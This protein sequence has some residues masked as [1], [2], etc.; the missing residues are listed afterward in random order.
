MLVVASNGAK[1]LQT[2]FVSHL[3]VRNDKF[4]QVISECIHLSSMMR[5]NDIEKYINKY[6]LAR[7]NSENVILIYAFTN[8]ARNDGR[9]NIWQSK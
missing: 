3:F 5:N 4:H 7:S 2:W 9:I 1:L 8:F 6:I